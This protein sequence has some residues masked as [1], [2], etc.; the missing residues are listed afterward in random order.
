VW[1]ALGKAYTKCTKIWKDSS[2]FKTGCSQFSENTSS[3]ETS[4]GFDARKHE[5]GS[6][7]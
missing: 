6:R 5:R 2:K 1:T 4:A 7:K 3:R